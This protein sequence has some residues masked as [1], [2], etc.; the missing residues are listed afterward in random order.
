M[1]SSRGGARASKYSK[2]QLAKWF[3]QESWNRYWLEN[4][5]IVFSEFEAEGADEVDTH[6]EA[7]LVRKAIAE[8]PKE[9]PAVRRISLGEKLEN[10]AKRARY[11]GA[12]SEISA[13]DWTRW[14][15]AFGRR[16]AYCGAQT[17]VPV[18]EHVVP[19]S[20]GGTDTIDNVVPSCMSCNRRKGRRTPFEWLKSE[21]RQDEFT[22][23]V[24]TALEAM[25]CAK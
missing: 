18:L 21:G 7:K 13:E 12:K 10:N 22:D 5:E 6:W 17:K 25:Q 19:L 14:A 1:N 8:K 15:E 11:F 2:A 9:I 24:L 4:E 23:R 16:C 3:E 20:R